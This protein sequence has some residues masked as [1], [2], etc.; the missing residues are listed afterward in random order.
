[1]AI[2]PNKY[3]ENIIS[4]DYTKMLE[5]LQQETNIILVF[6]TCHLDIATLEAIT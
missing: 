3:E 2:F 5:S 1:V 6:Y 4:N